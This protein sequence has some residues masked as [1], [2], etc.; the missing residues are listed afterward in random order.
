M[1]PLRTVLEVLR[2]DPEQW[3]RRGFRSPREIAVMVAERSLPDE[4]SYGDFFV[5]SR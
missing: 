5:P 1:T 3:R 2:T 4:P